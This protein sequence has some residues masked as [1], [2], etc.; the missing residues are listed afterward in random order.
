MY[1]NSIPPASGQGSKV[2]VHTNRFAATSSAGNLQRANRVLNSPS[3]TFSHNRSASLPHVSD[4]L[5]NGSTP[6]HPRFTGDATPPKNTP[7]RLPRRRFLPSKPSPIHTAFP[8]TPGPPETHPIILEATLESAK[9]ST[10][11]PC[12]PFTKP[13]P[14]L[15]LRHLISIIGPKALNIQE[16]LG[17]DDMIAL[18]DR[19]SMERYE[20]ESVQS[21]DMGFSTY[22]FLL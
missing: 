16:T 17:I 9:S 3:S 8:S 5:I 4:G 12:R 11:R 14:R 21:F 20:R 7:S 13:H 18:H 6:Y 19:E 2:P 1:R 10:P 22:N 15:L